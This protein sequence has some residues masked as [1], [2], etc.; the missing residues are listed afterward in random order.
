MSFET[1]LANDIEEV[2]SLK[3]QINALKDALKFYADRDHWSGSDNQHCP[4]I[5]MGEDIDYSEAHARFHGGKIARDVL[6]KY[7]EPK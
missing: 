5:I 6:S 3:E 1:T 2:Y 4:A 7:K